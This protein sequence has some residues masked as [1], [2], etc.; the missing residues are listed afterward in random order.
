MAGGRGRSGVGGRGGGRAADPKG[1]R[2][3]DHSARDDD[4]PDHSS[5]AEMQSDPP[6]ALLPRRIATGRLVRRHSAGLYR[7]MKTP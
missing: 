7:P 6:R 2:S 3:D 1:S 4:D 5:T